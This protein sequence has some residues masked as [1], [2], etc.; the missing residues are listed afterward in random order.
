MYNESAY[1]MVNYDINYHIMCYMFLHDNSK[2]FS[3]QNETTYSIKKSK[4]YHPKS[5]KDE[6]DKA[7]EIGFT[8]ISTSAKHNKTNDY[9]GV[10]SNVCM[11][12]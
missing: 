2:L 3:K 1:Q 12:F 4:V 9:K 7:R 6:Y 5:T 11:L 8:N 10:L